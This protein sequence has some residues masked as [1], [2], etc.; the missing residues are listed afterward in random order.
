MLVSIKARAHFRS[1]AM[2]AKQFLVT[3]SLCRNIKQR[4]LHLN[5]AKYRTFLHVLDSSQKQSPSSYAC[6]RST[7]VTSASEVTAVAIHLHGGPHM[8]HM[9]GHCRQ[10]LYMYSSFG[11]VIIRSMCGLQ[12]RESLCKTVSV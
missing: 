11:G 10:L 9:L 2:H 1:F 8:T 12:L 4:D 3:A 6:A 5:G 7:S